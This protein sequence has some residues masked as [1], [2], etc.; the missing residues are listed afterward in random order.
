[1][2]RRNAMEGALTGVSVSRATVPSGINRAFATTIEDNDFFGNTVDIDVL[3]GLG[4]NTNSNLTFRGNLVDSNQEL[5]YGRVSLSSLFTNSNANGSQNWDISGN[6]IRGSSFNVGFRTPSTVPGAQSRL[7]VR[8]NLQS[9][10]SVNDNSTGFRVEL[11][12]QE[13]DVNIEGNAFITAGGYTPQVVVDMN[14]SNTNAQVSVRGNLFDHTG[15]G[16]GTG[17]LGHSV[18]GLDAGGSFSGT[19]ENNVFL[20]EGDRANYGLIDVNLF[21]MQAAATL[22]VVHNTIAGTFE[23]GLEGDGSNAATSTINIVDNVITSSNPQVQPIRDETS[24]NGATVAID[25]NVVAVATTNRAGDPSNDIIGTPIFVNP[26]EERLIVVVSDPLNAEIEVVSGALAVGDFV[27]LDGE[28]MEREVLL[29]FGPTLTLAGSAV[30]ETSGTVVDA[31]GWSSQTFVS[32]APDY[33]LAA[34]SPGFGAARDQG[35]VGA[36]G[37]PEPFV[38]PMLPPPPAQ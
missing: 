1:T 32:P 3:E 26:I 9:A 5:G 13:A 37:G 10:R 14:N 25:N 21:N 18:G 8:D 7:N 34:S 20:F 36:F 2:I 35:D 17:A 23:Y 38:T 31:L 28:V 30:A 27:V 11:Y 12:N 6:D 15:G 24:V 22:D 29:A 16:S 4:T 19:V 33:N